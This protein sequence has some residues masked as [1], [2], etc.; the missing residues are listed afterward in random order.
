VIPEDGKEFPIIEET[1]DLTQ[2][3]QLIYSSFKKYE[4]YELENKSTNH[5]NC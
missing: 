4:S 5:H 1:S 3:L 2:S